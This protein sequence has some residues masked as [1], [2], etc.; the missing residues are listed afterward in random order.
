MSNELTKHAVKITGPYWSKMP[1]K[2]GDN[3]RMKLVLPGVTA[4][5]DTLNGELLFIRTIIGSGQY[6]GQS[7]FQKSAQTC[8]D[9][10]MIAPFNPGA[11]DKLEGVQAEFV[12]GKREYDGKVYDEVKFINPMRGE[13]IDADE[14]SRIFSALSG[15]EYVPKSARIDD[16]DLAPAAAPTSDDDLPF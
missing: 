2:D 9:L 1:E 6:T 14:A 15:D 7:V 4:N 13:V 8:F 16:P 3:N 11:I 10:G 5:G 12:V